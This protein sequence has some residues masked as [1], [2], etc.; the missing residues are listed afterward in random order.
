MSL[1]CSLILGYFLNLCCLILG[2]YVLQGDPTTC[3]FIRT[4]KQYGVYLRKRGNI[5]G[6]KQRGG[7][8]DLKQQVDGIKQ[9]LDGVLVD[10]MN[11]KVE[12]AELKSSKMGVW[13]NSVLAILCLGVVTGMFVSLMCK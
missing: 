13:D 4:E 9:E 5:E 12:M 6:W 10:L 3:N 8:T 2:W 1:L 7:D 11:L